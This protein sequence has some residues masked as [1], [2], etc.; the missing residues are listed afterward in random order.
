E[1]LRVISGSPTDVQPVFD[2]IIRSAVALCRGLM[3]TVFRYDG[4]QIHFVT[5]HNLSPEGLAEYQRAY[6]RPPSRDRLMGPAL[7]GR[8]PVNVPDVLEVARFVIGQAELGFRSVV[9][10]PMVREGAAIGGIAVSRREIGLF[11]D[12]QVELLQTFAEQAVIAIENVRLFNE[13]DARN[14]D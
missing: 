2:A 11:P 6:P 5:G 3:G 9:L 14:R 1:I 7:L 12:K 4:E 10:V 8:R 13:L